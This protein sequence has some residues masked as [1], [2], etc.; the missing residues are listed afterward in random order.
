MKFSLKAITV[1]FLVLFSFAGCEKPIEPDFSFSP[2]MPKAGQR[3]TFTNLTVGGVEW[4]WTFGDGSKSLLKN[5]TYIYRKPGKYDITLRADSNDNYIT[6]KTIIIYDT[7]PSIYLP[8]DTVGYFQSVTMQVLAYNPYGYAVSYEWSFSANAQGDDLVSGK[9]TKANPVVFYTK[10]GVEE[11]VSLKIKVGDTEDTV[12]KKIFVKDVPSRSML[13]A[14]TD[15]KIYRQRIYLNGL[16]EPFATSLN[17]GGVH[18]LNIQTSGEYLYVFNAGNQL[19]TDKS[20]LEGIQGSGNIRKVNMANAQ[21]IELIHNRD[22]SAVHGFYNGWVNNGIIYWTDFAD[23]VYRLADNNQIAGSFS[24]KGNP[25]DQT[26]VPY[27]LL[28]PDRLGYFGNGLN[29]GQKN[30]GFYFYDQVYFWAKGGSGRGIYRFTPS[31]IHTANVA[32]RGVS[33]S[34]GAILTDYAIHAFR[35]DQINQ[36]IYFSVVSPADKAGLWVANLTGTNPVRIDDSPVDNPALYIAAILIDNATNRVYWSYRAPVGLSEAH[37]QLNPHHRT[38]VK[39]VRLARNFTV[40]R[41]IKFMP[42]N[43]SA[44]GITFDETPR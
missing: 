34:L 20:V 40:D 28:K 37:F 4:D 15:G 9:S 18:P 35:I 33:P 32:G 3:V 6:K 42:G 7:I 29:F 16:E 36:K 26:T 44:L 31:D 14:G 23:F 27:Y 39:Y 21:A 13:I 30:G 22:V 17:A 1:L 8:S 11:I 41:E 2:E 10:K 38:G 19:S 12:T 5:P 25:D 24:W 43:L